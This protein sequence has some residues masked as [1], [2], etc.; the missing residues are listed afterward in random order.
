MDAISPDSNLIYSFTSL[1]KKDSSAYYYAGSSEEIKNVLHTLQMSFSDSSQ[2]KK[3]C[4]VYREKGE[5][6]VKAKNE[7]Q[8]QV[9]DVKG[10]GLKDALYLCESR[11]IH[12]STRGTGKV[13][14]QT[15]VPGT[16]VSKNQKLI[17]E[18][19]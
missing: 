7:E 9:P 16:I 5:P 12:V 3:W 4:G 6:V 11:N 10:M 14:F 2:D 18:L 1:L 8:K 15:I 13:K 19:N 17:L